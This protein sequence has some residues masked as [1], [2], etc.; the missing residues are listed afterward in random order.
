MFFSSV[1]KQQQKYE[2]THA[3]IHS[4]HLSLRRSA[5]KRILFFR[6]KSCSSRRSRGIIRR[7]IPFLSVFSFRIIPTS[8]PANFR[9]IWLVF[10]KQGERELNGSKAGW[11]QTA[12]V[13]V[14]LWL[15]PSRNGHQMLFSWAYSHY[16]LFL[17]PRS[18]ALL[19][20]H[21]PSNGKKSLFNHL[22]RSTPNYSHFS[23]LSHVREKM[24]AAL[25]RVFVL[26]LGGGLTN[27][28]R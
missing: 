4:S 23:F 16:Y 25:S 19:P 28:S 7:K 8:F 9:A 14:V 10:H 15:L 22:R 20:D 21:H 5:W 26:F 12:E 3:Y 1:C 11:N 18:Y 27:T 17:S 24:P 13:L 2:H 6:L